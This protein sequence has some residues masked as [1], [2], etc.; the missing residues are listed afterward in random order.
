MFSR[1]LTQLALHPALI[2]SGAAALAYQTSWTRMLHRVFGVGDLAVATVL[3]AYFLGLGLG[4]FAAGRYAEKVRRP[5]LGYAVL[6]VVI[7]LFAI[8]SVWLI[9]SLGRA[10]IAIGPDAGPTSLALWRLLLALLVLLPP[11][12]LMGA[13]LPLLAR[14]VQS[15]AGWA[16]GVTSLYVSNTLG[17]V[18]GVAAAGLWLIPQHGGRTTTFLAGAA[19]FAAAALV[20]AAFGR[21]A[22]EPSSRAAPEPISAEGAKEERSG[23]ALAVTLA[24]LTGGASIA[25]EVLW[26]RVLRTFLH[27]TTQ[28]FA[29]MLVTYLLGIA[30]GA[31]IARRLVRRGAARMLGVTQLLA[32]LLI[33]GAMAATP[34]VMRLVPL[35]H[36]QLSFAPHDAGTILAVSLLLLFPLALV[37]GT[38]LPLAF[39]LAER[40]DT[41]AGKGSG[42]LLAANT[43]AGLAGSLLAGFVLVP[44]MGIEASLL[45]VVFV[46][47][48]AAGLAFRS[49]TTARSPALRSAVLAS[50]LAIGVALIYLGPSVNLPFLLRAW[51]EPTRALVEGPGPSWREPIVYLQEGRSATVTVERSPGNLRLL[52]DGRPESGFGGP[53]VGFGAELVLLGSLPTLF[54]EERERAL[55]IGLGGAHTT[56]LLLAGGFESVDV[57]ELE[58]AVVGAARLMYEAREVPF[59]LDDP[60]ARLIIDDARNRLALAED[61]SYDAVVSQP[62]HPWLAGS[63]ALY[64]REFF[65]D[66]DRAL[67]DGGVF[68]LWINTFRIRPRQ[69]RA[70][71]HTLR[72]V[73]PYVS[74]FVTEGSSLILSA[75]RRPLRWEAVDARM[76]PMRAAFL[77][78]RGL[79]SPT[80]L[81][82][83]LEIDA[84]DAAAFG[85]GA[86][87][88]VDDRPLLEIE[89]AATPASAHVR[90]R[91]LDRVLEE[92]GWGGALLERWGAPPAPLLMARIER[93]HDRP[94]ALD[95]LER[96]LEQAELALSDRALVEGVLAEAWGDIR[97]ALTAWDR[98]ASPEAAMRADRLRLAE[99]MTGGVL[100]AARER[101]VAPSS[102]AALL[103]AALLV[104]EARAFETALASPVAVEDAPLRELVARFAAKGCA[105]WAAEHRTAAAVLARRHYAI[106]VTAQECAYAEGDRDAAEELG[107]L[108]V[109]ARRTAAVSAF[110]QGERCFAGG[111]GGCALMMFRRALREYPSHSASA[112]ALARMLHRAGRSEEAREV[113]LRTLRETEGI[114]SSQAGLHATAAQLGLDIGAA[115]PEARSPSSTSTEP[116][117]PLRS[118]D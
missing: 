37:L 70:V 23:V 20:F 60:R 65:E 108:A 96:A 102:S 19:S 77:A 9:P 118:A 67:K 61:G 81:A 107:T 32:A 17:A 44:A 24:A 40:A 29:G 76:E 38:G 52:S 25:G 92:G 87:L 11:T 103:S 80:A 116:E 28:A 82:A 74:G 62:S 22:L 42:L 78:P 21:A 73:F 75:S 56:A 105:G 35:L 5:A 30:L 8:G 88:I 1:T 59:P 12:L 54:A 10:Y 50:P 3:A 31:L 39:G 98:A 95:R 57:V 2:L 36:R 49:A 66:V 55:A 58:E 48:T 71:V 13:T 4:S 106:A 43:L 114:P 7:G 93:V 99:G 63:S 83:S 14:L 91:D 18:L 34:H 6:E 16:R 26:T 109:R 47:L 104:N 41:D 89:L 85:A 112:A 86:P 115:P 94:R 90:P 79:G 64:T 113:L 45:A 27:A 110:D 84:G 69:I 111:N 46:H 15:E 51:Q 97:G 53:P 101:A 100:R 68:S 72:E 117:A 33:V